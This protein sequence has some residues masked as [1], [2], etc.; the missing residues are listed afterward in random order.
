MNHKILFCQVYYLLFL[1]FAV[2]IIGCN[3]IEAITDT[4]ANI[5]DEVIP[6]DENIEETISS[7]NFTLNGGTTTTAEFLAT[8]LNSN[9]DRIT[10]P[11]QVICTFTNV[12]T[13][14]L[15]TQSTSITT[16]GQATCSIFNGDVNGINFSGFATAGGVNSNNTT[17]LFLDGTSTT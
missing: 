7:V 9:G 8:V 14:A 1:T 10:R 4:Y 17:S 2:G 6:E 16:N 12:N 11:V 3:P 15:V 5:I 13:Q